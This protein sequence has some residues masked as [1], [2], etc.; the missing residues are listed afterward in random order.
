MKVYIRH[1]AEER[2]REVGEYAL[3]D[4]EPLVRLYEKYGVVAAE[5]KA[6]DECVFVRATF[7]REGPEHYLEV[8]VDDDEETG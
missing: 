5:D 8:L 3:A 6:Y 4:L 7:V 1:A 2:G